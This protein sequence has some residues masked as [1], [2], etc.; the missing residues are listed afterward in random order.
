MKIEI[1][2]IGDELLIGQTVNT[3]ASWIGEQLINIGIQLQ[4]VTTV[5]DSAERLKQALH[6]AE[7]R[8]DVILLTGGL[9][10]THDDVTKTIVCEYFDSQ[11]VVNEE[12]LQRVKERFRKRGYTMAK[13]NEEQARVPHNADIMMND[14]GTAPGMIFRQHDK[15][16]FV[17]PGVPREMQSMMTSYVLP[18]LKQKL[19]GKVILV[20]NLM[21]TGVPESTL[22]EQLDNLQ[23]V[24][25]LAHIAFLPNLYGVKLRLM[26][27]GDSKQEAQDKL[28][29][30]E[31]LIRDKIS[32]SIYSEGEVALEEVV[33][34]LLSERH[35]TLA[36]AESCTG[37]MVSNKVTN[38]SGS[39]QFFECG[40]ITYSNAAKIELLGVP[41]QLIETHGA[42]SEPVARSMAERVREVAGTTYGLSVTGIAGPTGGTAEKP[43]GLVFVGYADDNGSSVERHTFANDRVGNKQRSTQAVLNLLRKKM[44]ERNNG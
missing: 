28:D 6:I 34:T 40:L 14:L 26:T 7:S 18:E 19:N 25:E 41:R 30:A 36:I 1:I 31:Q 23:K 33:A 5:G 11:L 21:T 15:T 3:N 38:I 4:W 37:G 22:Y 16:V 12:V 39:S 44:I 8:S 35:E 20:K 42:V 13:V 10:P 24:E 43:V 27:R 17:M 29:R 9:G 32:A 2:S